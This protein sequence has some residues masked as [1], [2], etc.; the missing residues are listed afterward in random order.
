MVKKITAVAGLAFGAAMMFGVANAEPG[1]VAGMMDVSHLDSSRE[2]WEKA[3]KHEFYVN[4][5]SIGD[6]ITQVDGPN[7]EAAQKAAHDESLT[8]AG[9]NTC[10]PVWRGMVK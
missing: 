8:K 2:A 4:C 3:G 6:Y 9:G 5:T 1:Y 10:W 7:R